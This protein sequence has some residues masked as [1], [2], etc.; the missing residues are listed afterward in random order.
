MRRR[1]LSLLFLLAAVAPALRAADAIS[2]K[3]RQVGLE[4]V[5]ATDNSPTLI[6]FDVRNTTA[7]SMPI[8]LVVDEVSLESDSNS[9][10]TSIT[11]PLVLSL[12]EERTFR[13]PLHIIPQNNNKLVIYLEARDEG[14]HFDAHAET[15]L[16]FGFSHKI[17][18]K[19]PAI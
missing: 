17:H 19:K 15:I 2:L 18:L 6:S 10:T 4:N 9:V 1:A 7:Q 3:F 16:G 14:F 12:G 5:Y 8:S 11:L 13:V